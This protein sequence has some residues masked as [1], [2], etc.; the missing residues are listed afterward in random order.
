MKLSV[1]FKELL[2]NTGTFAVGLLL[3]CLMIVLALMLLMI[4]KTQVS[5]HSILGRYLVFAMIQQ[6]LTL[7][8]V[9]V[10]IAF[11]YY[12]TLPVKSQQDKILTFMPILIMAILLLLSVLM[13]LISFN[14]FN[15]SV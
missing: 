10:I 5:Q 13:S 4:D 14:L 12:R 8:F 11:F 7:N 1:T 3:S 15:T 9:G 6:V 2:T